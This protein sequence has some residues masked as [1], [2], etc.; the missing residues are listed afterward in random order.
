MA[1]APITFLGE[2]KQNTRST[3][4]RPVG[5]EYVLLL[6]VICFLLPFIAMTYCYM[7]VYLKVRK[8]RIQLQSWS[9]ST[10]NME[11]ELKTAK[12]V[13]TVLAVFLICWLPFVTVYILSNSGKRQDISPAVFLLSGCL[14]AAHSV[15]NPV[16]YFTM[17]KS[18]RNDLKAW[19]PSLC[20]VEQPRDFATRGAHYSNNPEIQMQEVTRENDYGTWLWSHGTKASKKHNVLFRDCAVIK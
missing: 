2:Y 3:N 16:I 1:L 9:A 15:C 8:Q 13:F 6:S 5:Q 10:P 18:F 12:I 19:F 17:N 14:T 11:A 7:K 20:K 4:C